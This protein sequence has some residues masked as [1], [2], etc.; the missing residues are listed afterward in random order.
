MRL[1]STPPQDTA[2]GELAKILFQLEEAG[3]KSEEDSAVK[4]KSIPTFKKASWVIEHRLSNIVKRCTESHSFVVGASI[5]VI[6]IVFGLFYCLLV[7]VLSGSTSSFV[8]AWLQW[9]LKISL[10]LLAAFFALLALNF[11]NM[12]DRVHDKLLEEANESLSAILSELTQ[13]NANVAALN[14]N[15]Q[16]DGFVP[17]TLLRHFDEVLHTKET[18][19]ALEKV[20][21]ARQRDVAA[22]VHGIREHQERARRAA[23]AAAGGVF[24]G[25]F[26]FEVGESVFKF[27]HLIHGQDDRS[28]FFWL[29]T[30]AQQY[31]NP[32][33]VNGKKLV[34]MEVKDAAYNKCK[35]T[36]PADKC[37][38][39]SQT[40][41]P[42]QLQKHFREQY[43]QSEMHAYGLLLAITLLVS[44]IAAAIGWRKPA[45]EQVGGH[46][47]HH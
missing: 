19:A 46:G 3:P 14:T 32:D 21:L 2:F 17:E 36:T 6:A 28:M 15:P 4:E 45:E 10:A 29:S 43:Q 24:T 8:P 38:T 11:K 22:Q 26:V 12:E 7:P 20:I 30:E 18:V 33:L 44:L 25:F 13:T 42:T 27:M 16:A 41:E 37:N 5:T 23:T 31:A 34:P 9:L 40:L 1:I 47:G 35:L 39:S